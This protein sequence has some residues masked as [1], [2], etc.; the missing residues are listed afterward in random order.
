M[1]IRCITK[2]T[3]EYTILLNRHDEV[4]ISLKET[5]DA[6]IFIYTNGGE[7]SQDTGGLESPDLSVLRS[8]L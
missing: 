7:I 6:S 8:R 4:V 5:E 3:E 2:V 1:E